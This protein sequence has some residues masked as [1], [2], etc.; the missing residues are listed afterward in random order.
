MDAKR[1]HMNSTLALSHKRKYLYQIPDEPNFLTLSY[2]R[3]L[4]YFIQALARGLI[5]SNI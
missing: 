3:N 4:L 1:E 5:C 2:R